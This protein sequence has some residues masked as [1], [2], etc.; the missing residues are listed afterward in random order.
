[1]LVSCRDPSRPDT[2][3]GSNNAVGKPGTGGVSQRRARPRPNDCTRAR[4]RERVE[5][6]LH[7][8]LAGAERQRQGRARPG[9]PVGEQR[10]D[11]RM[12]GRRPAAPARRPRGAWR[13]ASAKPRCVAPM[14]ASG[15][16]IRR[17]RPISTRSRARCDSS[18]S[19]PPNAPRDQ[20]LARGIAGPGLGQRAGERE[21]DRAPR[22]R[23]H[24]CAGRGPD[25]GRRR[26]PS[27]PEACSASTSSSRSGRSAPPAISRAAGVRSAR[28]ALS[29]SA[30]SAAIPACRAARSARASA[31]R[32][33][34]ARSRRRAIPASDQLVRGP[35]RRRQGCRIEPGQHPLGLVETAEQDAAAAARDSA[36]A[37][38]W[39]GRHAVRAPPAPPSSAAAGQPRSRETKAISAS[40]TTQRARATASLGP[41][42]RPARRSSARARSR[43][44][45]CAIA[46]PRSASA[47]GSSR[48]ATRFSA[49]SG[50]PAASARAAAVISESIPIPPHLSLSPP[51][52]CR[53]PGP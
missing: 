27:A 17:S 19:L 33:A 44:P 26:R 14:P 22:Q 24:A 6:P 20:Q 16:S 1:M 45:S 11:R 32:A 18:A 23:H 50:S 9:L 15:R 53:H 31:A 2:S 13:G 28:D 10:R 48:S 34:A 7:G 12:L 52:P 36:R 29:T 35:C 40:A 47:G 43:S 41:K 8:A 49:P 51:P 42:A 5:R 4:G 39:P 21:Q 38:R 25:A 46:M 30:I 37:R 3:A